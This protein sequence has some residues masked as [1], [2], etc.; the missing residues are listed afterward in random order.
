MPEKGYVAWIFGGYAD[1]INRE[2]P[3]PVLINGKIC[4]VV[5][6]CMDTFC[7]YTG[8]YESKVG[9]VVQLQNDLLTPEYIAKDT[10]TIPYV[11]MT[12][13]VGRV[14]RIYRQ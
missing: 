14:N 10:S 4:P 1:G 13:R 9:E 2:R 5:A 8:E 11:V 7:A 12:S 3:Q 6:V